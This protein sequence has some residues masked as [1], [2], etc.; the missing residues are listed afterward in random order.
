MLIDLKN[1]FSYPLNEDFFIREIQITGLQGIVT[2]FFLDGMSD[3]VVIEDHIIK[4][5][6][7]VNL[8]ESG[9]IS[10]EFLQNVIQVK[11]I[12][13]ISDFIDA[14]T[15]ILNGNTILYAEQFNFI[16]SLATSK[17]EHRAIDRPQNEQVLKGPNEGFIE[18]AQINRS[19]IR[20]QLRNEH[21]ISESMII[22][23]RDLSKVSLLYINNLVNKELLQQV[24][25]KI[26]QI[27]TDSLGNISLLEQYME[28][29]PYSLVPT[30]LYTERPDRAA[31]FLQ[32]GHIVVI[33]E[34]SPACLIVP[35]TFW[36][37]F[38]TAEDMYQRLLIGN[39]I[40]FIRLLGFFIALI[41]PALYIAST[42]Y[43]A[44]MIP[45][46]LLL[47]ISARRETVPFPA[48]IEVLMMEIAFELIR[49]AGIRIPT[50]MGPTIGIVGAL[51]LGQASVEAN[52]ISPILVIVVAITGMASFAIPEISFSFM[53]R[54]TRFIFLISAALFGLI[55]IT[56]FMCFCVCY[57]ASIRS[58][59]VAFL[60]PKAPHMSASQDAITRG[61]L[62]KQWLRPSY[63]QP[64][65]QQRKPQK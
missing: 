46:D 7:Q 33:M 6:M 43:H 22:G 65:D 28:E 20:K 62:W 25:H 36:S 32:E 5:L 55:G 9:A 47:A 31:A 14:K 51:I 24:K 16:L 3:R 17:I 48:I 35:V 19:L 2:L 23:K 53:I 30:V 64:Q 4:P 58:F 8:L 50:P 44:E 49:E 39:F 56:V 54:I 52:I 59:G 1:A 12:Q 29:R 26:L 61:L 27:N 38:H 60:S 34:N 21:L 63:T 18:S 42:N 10:Q 40:R 13:P 15:E 45:T 11:G 41:T 37:F 57:L